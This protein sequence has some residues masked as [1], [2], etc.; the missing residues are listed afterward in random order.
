MADWDLFLTDARIATMRA[1]EP[2]YGVIEDAAIA[3]VDGEIAWL[4]AA[5]D[6][7]GHNASETRSLGNRWVTPAIIDC[8]THLVFGGDRAEDY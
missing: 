1:D 6:K 3:I 8:H 2:D 5:S 7:P 4:G